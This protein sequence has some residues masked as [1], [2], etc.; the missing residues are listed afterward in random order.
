MQITSPLPVSLSHEKQFPSQSAKR[1]GSVGHTGKSSN[2]DGGGDVSGGEGGEGG[3]GGGEG[4][5]GGGGGDIGG[6]FSSGS[7]NSTVSRS[8]NSPPEAI[9]IPCTNIVYAPLPYAQHIP[10]PNSSNRKKV[11]LPSRTKGTS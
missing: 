10:S 9:L 5:E 1:L 11:Y 6:T 4:G 8:P 2:F 7:V 3:G